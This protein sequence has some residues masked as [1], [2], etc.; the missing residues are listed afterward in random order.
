MLEITPAHIAPKETSYLQEYGPSLISNGYKIVPIRRGTKAPEGVTGWTKIDADHNQ[1]ERWISKGYEGVGVL[2]KDNPG[3]DIDVLDEGVSRQMVGAVLQRYPGGLVRVGKAPKTLLSYR[4]DK[5]FKKVRSCTYEDKDGNCHAVEILGNGQQYVAYAEHPDTLQPYTWEG[6]GIFEVKANDLPVLHHEDALKI[7]TMF[8][9]IAKEKLV[10]AGWVKVREGTVGSTDASSSGEASGFIPTNFSVL[11][12]PLD[13]TL[14]QIRSDLESVSP[15]DYNTWLQ[16]GMALWHQFN[17]DEEGFQLWDEWST[18]S[19]SYTGV[20]ALCSRWEGLRPDPNRR[21]ITFATVRR[22]ANEARMGDDPLQAFKDRFV[23]V[24]DGD[25]VYDLEGLAHDKPATLKEFRNM[26]A[27]IRM[28]I[29]VPAP[30]L[31][32]DDRTKFKMV[33]VHNQWMV[34]LERKSAQGFTYVPGK[35]EI[36]KDADGRQWINTF[37]MPDFANPCPMVIKNGETKMEPES[38][39]SLLGVF[40]RHMEY[41]IPVEEE[42][43]WFYSWM[44]FNLQYP[45]KRCKVTPLL[46]ATAHGTGRG[47]IVQLM[48]LLLGSWNCSKTKMSTLNGDSSAG[49][50]QEFMNDKLLCAV[51]E[52]KDADKPYGVLDS[53]RSYLTEDT[54]EINLK[55]GAKETKRVHTNF[56]W[57]SNHADALV[58]KAEDRRISV[59]KTVDGPKDNDYYDR[60]YRWLE[61]EDK[62]NEYVS[63]QEETI[64]GEAD[65][66]SE[67]EVYDRAEV[68]V[69]TGMACLYHWLKNRDLTNFDE[70]RSM[71]NKA[72]QDLI[73]NSQTDIEYLFLELVKNPPYEVMTLVEI[74]SE[75]GRQKKDLSSDS[76]FLTDSEKR[77]IKKL[78]Q[79]HLGKQ[80]RIKIS[81][82]P[83]PEGDGWITLDKPYEVHYWSLDKKNTFST[84]EMRAIHGARI[85]V[86]HQHHF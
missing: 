26:Y 39:D 5:P 73:E 13:I 84:K 2:C 43:E 30:V 3:V 25:A 82:E 70:K 56:L 53:I 68:N 32:N 10:F 85:K 16:V 50:Y 18:P 14:R 77:Q 46:I 8:E 15:D 71:P 7:V 20:E 76:C 63:I 57:N 86:V 55:Y 59:F 51:E 62:T 11:R 49:Q 47:W 48:N 40:F 66:E 17:G 42:R 65:I 28:E 37:H 31:G 72:R 74:E 12:P 27:N 75:L 1:L 19:S 23:Y 45:E 24:M 54:L 38:V 9:D 79:L 52:V 36:L 81:R 83:E 35:S 69:S 22:W 33:P 60:L 58:L 6:D 64:D 21:P 44:A 61:A 29:E 34:D 67:D 41:I 4:T 78:A 80:E